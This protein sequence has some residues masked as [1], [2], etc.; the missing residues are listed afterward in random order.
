MKK[1][2]L[3]TRHKYNHDIVFK[4][5]DI[6]NNTKNVFKAIIIILARNWKDRFLFHWN[7]DALRC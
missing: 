1:G 5:I 7:R 4:I 2:D 6:K 3:V